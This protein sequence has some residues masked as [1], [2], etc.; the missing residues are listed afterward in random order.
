MVRTGCEACRIACSIE[1]RLDPA[2]SIAGGARYLRHLLDRMPDSVEAQDRVLPKEEPEASAAVARAMVRA[3]VRVLAGFG[4]SSVA[5][6]TSASSWWAGGSV[7]AR[8]A[9]VTRR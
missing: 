6:T 1:N 7:A 2:Q 3:G 9:Q 5:S 8:V 4:V